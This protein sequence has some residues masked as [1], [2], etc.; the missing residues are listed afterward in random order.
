MKLTITEISIHRE[1]QSPIFGEL[2]TEVKLADEGGGMFVKISQDSDDGY[3]AVRLGFDEL[4]YLN[5]AILILQKQET[6]Q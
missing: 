3:S 1:D 2:T 5:K 4:E 6:V